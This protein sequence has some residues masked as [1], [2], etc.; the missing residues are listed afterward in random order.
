MEIAVVVDY[1]HFFVDR[2]DFFEELGSGGP[3]DALDH[4]GVDGL[5]V[6]AHGDIEVHGAAVLVKVVAAESVEDVCKGCGS[7]NE[8]DQLV[9]TVE[10][11]LG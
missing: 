9:G 4:L 3:L 6:D 8:V 10:S 11:L 1:I 2:F 7:V 5:K